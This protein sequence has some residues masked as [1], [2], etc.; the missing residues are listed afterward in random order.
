MKRILFQLLLLLMAALD[1]CVSNCTHYYDPPTTEDVDAFLKSNRQDM[2]TVV[3]Y[4]QSLDADFAAMDKNETTVFYDFEDHAIAQEDVINSLR[5][6]W[7][8]GC[9]HNSLNVHEN[10]VYFETWYRTRGD[11][12]CGI[13]RTLNGRGF[14][15]VQFQTECRPISD[16]WFYYFTDYEK[17]RTAPSRYD[18]MW[19]AEPSPAP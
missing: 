11:V 14:P 3:D 13:A 4:L 12:G 2:E 15:K 18:A 16:G 8:A 7:R 9:E 5:C 1:C 6:L 10:T 19:D 17:Y